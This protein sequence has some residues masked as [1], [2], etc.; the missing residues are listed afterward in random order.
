MV[1][2]ITFAALLTIA[3]LW[4]LGVAAYG[5]TWQVTPE[6]YSI[7][8]ALAQVKDGDT[9]LISEGVYTDANESFPLIIN[10]RVTICA[11]EGDHVVIDAPVFQTTLQVEADNVTIRN[12]TINLR[13]NGVCVTGDD[14]SMS[15]CCI[16][17]ANPEY[18]TSSC[19]VW[20]AGVYRACFTGCAFTDCG[21]SIAGPPI[22]QASNDKP[23]LTGLFEVGDDAE[24][25][26]SHTIRDCTVNQKPLLYLVNQKQ[27]EI[28]ADAGQLILAACEDMDVQNEDITSGSIGITLAYCRNVRLMKSRVNRCGIFGIYLACCSRCTLE[29]CVAAE[30][31]HGIDLRASQLLT[32]GNC[33]AINCEQGIFLSRVTDSIVQ[34]CSVSATGQ[35]YFLAGGSCNMVLGSAALYCENGFNVQKEKDM[36]I[37]ECALEGNTVCAARLDRSPTTLVNN[38]FRNNWVGAMVYG[39][40]SCTI[41][42]NHFENSLNCGLYIRGI[43]YSRIANNIFTGSEAASIQANGALNGTVLSANVT[44]VPVVYLP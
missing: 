19:G 22:S 29:G 41:L 11:K 8:E 3:I 16:T 5:E 36:L 10:R 34:A 25:F 23:V 2:R 28:K 38:T 26:T 6:G 15:N 32:I 37:T 13:R 9:I 40:A 30:T 31:N 35:G 14:F 18:L 20:L 33:Q 42:G 27:T 7:T 39:D 24:Y 44:D 4:L 43:A 17:L 1:K 21:V 12:I